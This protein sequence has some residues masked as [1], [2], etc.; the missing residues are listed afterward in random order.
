[1]MGNETLFED[2]V[3][4]SSR[5]GFVLSRMSASGNVFFHCLI[6][7]YGIQKG[8]VGYQKANGSG[9]DHHMHFKQVI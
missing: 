4:D 2:C 3:A 9:S 1:M 7:I 5:H 8:L 6:K